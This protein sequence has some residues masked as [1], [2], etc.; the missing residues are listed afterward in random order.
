MFAGRPN[1]P[2]LLTIFYPRYVLAI[3]RSLRPVQS[4]GKTGCRERLEVHRNVIDVKSMAFLMTLLAPEGSFVTLQM[5]WHKGCCSNSIHK[6][7]ILKV[8]VVSYDL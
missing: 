4:R 1:H 8:A 7:E 3:W 2:H 5:R 6:N